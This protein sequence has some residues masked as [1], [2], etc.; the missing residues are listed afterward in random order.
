MSNPHLPANACD[1]HVHVFDP[2]GYPYSKTRSYTPSAA[3][4]EQLSG[5]HRSLGVQRAVVVQPSVYGTDNRCTADAIRQL[6][7]NGRGVAV[8]CD[9]PAPA[10]VRSLWSAG[11]RGV[12]L[13]YVSGGD[14]V[15]ASR[16]KKDL[17]HLA[18]VLSDHP[19]HVQLYFPLAIL[20]SLEAEFLGLPHQVVFDHFADARGE[21]GL[22]QPG[23][24]ALL[25]LVGSGRAHVKLSSLGRL[26][27][28]SAPYDDLHKLASAL[29]RASPD[30]VLWGTDWPHATSNRAYA[31]SDQ[32][33]M[34]HT[35]FI[36]AD[37]SRDLEIALQWADEL[38]AVEKIWRSNPARLYGWEK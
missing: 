20:E 26:S 1:C 29:I 16:I 30:H 13:N 15:S 36:D 7:A 4:L 8:L 18:T 11:F 34:P 17:R 35:R 2:G 37:D 38:S 12:R 24:S 5:L 27:C 3:S 22:G 9:D 31:D 14:T 33:P 23:F 32:G 19:W 6:G 21:R 25:R 10:V 28:Q